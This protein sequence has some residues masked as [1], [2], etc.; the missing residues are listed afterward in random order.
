[1]TPFL[2]HPAHIKTILKKRKKQD[3]WRIL[4]GTFY[5]C[6]TFLSNTQPDKMDNI[7][8]TRGKGYCMLYLIMFL[9]F[10]VALFLMLYNRNSILDFPK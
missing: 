1:L 3:R 5:F 9:F 6:R 2:K 7:Q 10:A 4:P 8:N